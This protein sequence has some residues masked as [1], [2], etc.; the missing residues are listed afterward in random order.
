MAQN[1]HYCV[2]PFTT[3]ITGLFPHDCI[4][5]VTIIHNPASSKQT[6]S[7]A[8]SEQGH[9]LKVP[10]QHRQSLGNSQL[11]VSLDVSSCR[12]YVRS[13]TVHHTHLSVMT[14]EPAA[15]QQWTQ[16]TSFRH[17]HSNSYIS[18]VLVGPLVKLIISRSTKPKRIKN[19]K[20]HKRQVQ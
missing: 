14:T 12:L 7:K 19:V 2:K 1:W 15:S 3:S 8:N 20:F 11:E 16:S 17:K 10:D 18:N 13:N 9:H 6:S 5:R 4:V